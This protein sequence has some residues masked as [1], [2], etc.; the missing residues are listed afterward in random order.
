MERKKPMKKMGIAIFCVL[1]L[2]VLSLV[3]NARAYNAAYTHTLYAAS[4]PPTIDGTYAQGDEWVASGTQTFGTNGIFR[5]QWTMSPNLACL[6]IETADGT[7]DAGDYWVVCYDST[8]T[9]TTTEPDGGPKPTAFDY[10]LVVTGH[11]ATAAVQW[12]KGTG[13]GWTSAGSATGGLTQAQTLSPYTPK[14]G[15]P[16]YVLELAIDKADTS[17]GSVPMGYNWA[18]YIA[19]YDAHDGG[20]G[21]QQ[22]P[23]AP[24]SA[25][26]PDSWGYIT[27]DMAANP[28][29]DVPESISIIAMLAVSSVAV[30]G[31]V[32]LRK[33]QRIANLSI[34]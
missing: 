9:G 23:P 21:L 11:G 18:N 5:D 8:E 26:V 1:S 28:T 16:H 15:T 7:N 6:L 30:A 19:Y 4:N 17:L 27:Y 22:W 3:G 25:D 13:T 32:L 10:K 14:I 29:P 12:Y 33:R 24:A 2:F 31:V 20:Y 34:N